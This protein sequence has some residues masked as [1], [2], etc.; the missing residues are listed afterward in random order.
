MTDYPTILQRLRQLFRIKAIT[1]F[2][3][4]KPAPQDTQ[5]VEMLMRSVYQWVGQ[6]MPLYDDQ[7]DQNYIQKGFQ[8]VADLYS[9]VSWIAQKGSELRFEVYDERTGKVIENHEALEVLYHPNPLMSREEFFELSYLFQLITGNTYNWTLPRTGGRGLLEMYVL[10]SQWTRIVSGG[11]ME[12]VAGYT[13]D[14]RGGIVY[15]KEQVL[16][17]KTSNPYFNS[18]SELYGMSPLKSGWNIVQ[19]ANSNQIAAKRAFDTQGAVGVLSKEAEANTF[20]TPEQFENLQQRVKKIISGPEKAGK[21]IAEQGKFNWI[22][23]GLSP[24]DLNLLKDAEATLLDVCNL[25]HVPSQLFNVSAGQK[26]DNME[27]AGRMAYTDAILPL[28]NRWVSKYTMQYIKPMYGATL[29]LRP[30]ISDIPEL[31][32]SKATQVEWLS[33]ATWLTVNEKRVEMD[34]EPKPDGD[35]ILVSGSDVPLDM[36]GL[37]R[38]IPEPQNE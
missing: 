3:G 2:V 37:D 20:T 16:H 31:Q 29:R 14:Y 1:P 5:S 4:V 13:L 11:W 18:G 10:P 19:K 28:V 36:V 7:N 22:N 17:V 33:K 8:A 32:T 9:V 23:F 24:V 35:V 12:P 21:I 30:I 15:P 38:A 26:Y 25:Y 34:Y 6:G 27:T